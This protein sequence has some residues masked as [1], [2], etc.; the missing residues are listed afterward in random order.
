MA[1]YVTS[2]RRL[3]ALST[4]PPKCAGLPCKRALTLNAAIE[5]A[6]AGA[7]GAPFA[8]IV[9]DMRQL[10]ARASD[11]SDKISRQTEILHAAVTTAFKE[12]ANQAGGDTSITQ[13]QAVIRGVVSHFQSMTTSLSGAIASMEQER[14]EVRGDISNALMQLQFQDRV[15]QILAHVA[16]SMTAMAQRAADNNLRDEDIQR[17]ADDMSRSFTTHEEFDNLGHQAHAPS[18]GSKEI[19]YF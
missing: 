19:T 10:A 7:A 3:S 13:A 2:A 9:G 12:S 16:Q 17:W 11:I 14:V 6:R 5:A 4:M 18:P 8:V 1:W 15:S